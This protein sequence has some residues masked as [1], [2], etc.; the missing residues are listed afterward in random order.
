MADLI[1]QREVDCDTKN[2]HR[3]EVEKQTEDKE[4]LCRATHKL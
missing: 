2:V 3:A 1:K 4:S